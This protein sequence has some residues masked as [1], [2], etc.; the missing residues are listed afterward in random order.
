MQDVT[1]IPEEN[2]QGAPEENTDVIPETDAEVL[3]DV[4]VDGT[5]TLTQEAPDKEEGTEPE[6]P[7]KEEPNREEVVPDKDEKGNIT[8]VFIKKYE[9]DKLLT[10]FYW[11]AADGTW[12]YIEGDTKAYL[13]AGPQKLMGETEVRNIVISDAATG[14]TKASGGYVLNI[15]DQ[16]GELEILSGGEGCSRNRKFRNCL[17]IQKT[18]RQTFSQAQRRLTRANT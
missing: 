15:S 12:S 10:T 3:A 11:N 1:G 5:D 17:Y 8:G 18:F 4:L 14:A 9:E 13:V 6:T 16:G 2:M 7:D